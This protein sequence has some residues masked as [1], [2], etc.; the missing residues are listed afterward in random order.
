M[1][2]YV[3][4]GLQLGGLMGAPAALWVGMTQSDGMAREIGLAVLSIILFYT[5]RLIETR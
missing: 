4:K 5:G 3:A 1:L 2:F